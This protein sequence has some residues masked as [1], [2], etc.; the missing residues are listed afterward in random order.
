MINDKN[1]E[2]CAFLAYLETW[3]LPIFWWGLQWEARQQISCIEV[4]FPFWFPHLD[5]LLKNQLGIVLGRRAFLPSFTTKHGIF[6]I[7]TFNFQIFI[8]TSMF[9]ILTSMWHL[10]N[11]WDNVDSASLALIWDLIWRH[12][13]LQKEHCNFKILERNIMNVNLIELFWSFLK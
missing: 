13:I 2:T 10:T 8:L 5:I 4:W 6:F 12:R 3:K 9:K 11:M 1:T 7:T